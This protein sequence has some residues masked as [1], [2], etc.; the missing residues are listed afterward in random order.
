MLIVSNSLEYDFSTCSGLIAGGT[1][2]GETQVE[3]SLGCFPSGYE[4][5]IEEKLLILG[6]RMSK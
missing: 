2:E 3:K 1:K 4:A 6:L 5:T